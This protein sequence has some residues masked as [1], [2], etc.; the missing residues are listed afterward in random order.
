MSNSVAVALS[1]LNPYFE[2]KQI[3]SGA[4]VTITKYSMANLKGHHIM[5]VG[6]I[7][8]SSIEKLN[9]K[10]GEPSNIE[11]VGREEVAAVKPASAPPATEAPPAYPPASTSYSSMMAGGMVSAGGLADSYQRPAPSSS[12]NNNMMSTGGIPSNWQ[13]DYSA[14]NMVKQQPSSS[15]FGNAI[16]IPIS[17]LSPYQN[18]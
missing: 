7:D 18:T 14:A 11:T 4:M 2:S 8:P 15:D 3:E 6:E 17:G 1:P 5:L 10:L 13:G 16:I 9:G 12:F